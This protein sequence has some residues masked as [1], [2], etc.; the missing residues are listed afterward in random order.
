MRESLPL[1]RTLGGLPAAQPGAAEGGV[2]RWNWNWPTVCPLCAW[3]HI[4]CFAS[5]IF[6]SCLKD[7][8]GL[9]SSH[10]AGEDSETQRQK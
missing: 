7:E 9:A 2:N 3:L 4:R 10:C 8:L 5:I 1:D 6:F